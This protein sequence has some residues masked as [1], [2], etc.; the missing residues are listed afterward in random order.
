MVD[1][2]E[3]LFNISDEVEQICQKL[4]LYKY[5]VRRI[6]IHPGDLVAYVENYDVNAEGKKYADEDGDPAVTR[7]EFRVRT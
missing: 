2:D 4:G 7:L 1:T 6:D 3:Q 5:R